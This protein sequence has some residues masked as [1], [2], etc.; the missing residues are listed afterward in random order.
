MEL[1]RRGADCLGV[2]LSKT[3]L[4]QFD[5]YYRELAEWNARVNLTAISGY[6]QT[7][8]R[9][10]LDSL[11]VCLALGNDGEATS[12]PTEGLRNVADIG[13]G[14][15]FPGLPFKLAFPGIQLHL[16]ES[17]GKKTAFLEHLVGALGL[18]GVTV[19]TGRAET[20]AREDALRESFDLVLVRGVARLSL[21]L[22]YALPLCRI[23]GNAV[24]LKHGG[25]EAEIAE[26][27]FALSELGGQVAGIFPVTLEGLTDNRVVAAFGKAAPTP[28]R[29]PRRAGIPS[30]RPL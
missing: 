26:A 27:E 22:E 10:F 20:L 28:D 2:P 3:Q 6:E 16:V 30:K 4:E 29:Y 7:Q 11:T 9:H 15:G 21:L 18:D 13:S 23:G 5:L 24:A 12:L 14:A 1:L 17:V 25:L 19:H 8:V